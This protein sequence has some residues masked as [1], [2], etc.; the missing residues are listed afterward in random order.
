MAGTGRIFHNDKLA[1]DLR[2]SRLS[3]SLTGENVGVGPSVE[4]IQNAFM[5][6][7]EHRHNI[8]DGRYNAIGVGVTSAADS[9]IYVAQVFAQV[10]A[11]TVTSAC[12]FITAEDGSR[13][14]PSYYG[15]SC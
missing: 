14:P 8:L 1:T 10:P 2:A 9:R 6:S 13:V 15:R 4:V 5:H 12:G 11:R 3:W 7:A